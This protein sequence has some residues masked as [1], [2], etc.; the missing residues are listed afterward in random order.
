MTRYKRLSEI[1]KQ[2]GKHANTIAKWCDTVEGAGVHQFERVNGERFFIEQ[3]QIVTEYISDK[4][5][6]KWSMQQI[7]HQMQLDL[8]LMA[9][10]E[11]MESMIQ[12]SMT[13][14]ANVIKQQIIEAMQQA[15][16]K[17]V[18]IQVK[19][20]K[21]HYDR[22]IVA[23]PKPQDEAEQ[24]RAIISA[25]LHKEQM[26]QELIQEAIEK[27]QLESDRKKRF[28]LWV[29]REDLI[30]RE[31]YIKNYVKEKMRVKTSDLSRYSEDK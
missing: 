13:P 15:I 25:I 31:E 9:H 16:D 7:M 24:Q 20:V 11:H 19:Q 8:D 30:K 22:M 6:D 26:E 4:R 10:V 27:W 29:Y 1:S 21:E 18:E 2:L 14:D 12:E 23:L 5:D 28:F 3:V 17:A